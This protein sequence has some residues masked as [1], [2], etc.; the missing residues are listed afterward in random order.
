MSGKWD[1]WVRFWDQRELADTLAI[2]RIG[3]GLTLV[4]D[5]M[6]AGALGL[7]VPLWAPIE[8]GGF[9]P[10]SYAEPLCGVYRWF[11]AS[12]TATWVLYGLTALLALCMT[13]G[14]FTR[15]SALLFV[16]GYAQLS[17]LSPAADRG[18]DNLL[19]NVCLL[20]AFSGAG[21]TLSLEARIFHGRFRRDALVPA[22][23]RY[24]LIL[25]L[26]L[27]YFGAGMLKQSAQWTSLDHYSA[28]YVVLNRP[29]IARFTLPPAL[30][31]ASY[32]FL[33]F[34]TFLTVLFE[35]SSPLIP[36]LLWLRATRARAGRVRAL[37]MRSRILPLWVG[38]GVGFHLGLAVLLQLGI[39][40]WGCLALYPAL[41]HPETL[42]AWAARCRA[43]LTHR[44]GPL[45]EAER[46]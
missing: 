46:A 35:R 21:A 36:V 30:Q 42:R 34:S 9:G 25:Q 26:M 40:P 44:R 43:Q 41:A 15:A 31:A 29:H 17:Q 39:F 6:T 37:A 19:R 45:P 12:A 32:P 4:W 3:V 33:Q 27:V 10:A 16:L 8:E 5:L 14:L 11:G 18:I 20:L 38:T 28:L 13:L 23:P 22:W 24:L 1:A 2:V 7:V